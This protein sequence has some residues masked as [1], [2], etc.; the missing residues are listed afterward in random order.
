MGEEDPTAG[1]LDDALTA[2]EALDPDSRRRIEEGLAAEEEAWVAAQV[3][4]DVSTVHDTPVGRYEGDGPEEVREPAL[5]GPRAG[6]GDAAA[7]PDAPQSRVD[8]AGDDGDGHDRPDG[9]RRGDVEA[10]DRTPDVVNSV[11]SG[12]SPES[13]PDG[14]PTDSV[15][16]VDGQ[17]GGSTGGTGGT[18]GSDG[19]ERSS[20]RSSRS[21]RVWTRSPG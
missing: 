5:L 6:T 12:T 11:D 19:R 13:V 15:R 20:R 4:E 14:S 9:D 16:V 10:G 2:V 1:E 7:S 18:G 17:D 21:S 8:L 3:P